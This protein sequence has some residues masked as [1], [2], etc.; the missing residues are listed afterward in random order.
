MHKTK[1]I[2]FTVILAV[3]GAIAAI[4]GAYMSGMEAGKLKVLDEATFFIVDYDDPVE[5]EGEVYDTSLFIDFDGNVYEQG[6]YV[7]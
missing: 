3:L 4:A 6:L 7:C 5:F 1:A 2:R